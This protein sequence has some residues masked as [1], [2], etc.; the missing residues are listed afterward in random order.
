MKIM[1][2]IDR[3]LEFYLPIISIGII[4]ILNWAS[5]GFAVACI[6]LFFFCVILFN[7]C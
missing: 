1:K 7:E 5:Y 2:G 4:C 3:L 6:F